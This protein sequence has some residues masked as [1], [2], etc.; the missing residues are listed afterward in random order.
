MYITSNAL[1]NGFVKSPIRRDVAIGDKKVLSDRLWSALR[2]K[3][4][5]MLSQNSS[6]RL[7]L[8]LVCRPTSNMVTEDKPSLQIGVSRNKLITQ[9]VFVFVKVQQTS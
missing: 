6:I 3:L 2:D 7:W 5:N 1:T 4:H 8:A 9:K